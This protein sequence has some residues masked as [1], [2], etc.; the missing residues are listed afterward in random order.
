MQ[1]ENIRARIRGY[2]K[3]LTISD[4]DLIQQVNN[5]V[6][7]EDKRAR[8]LRSQ[9]RVKSAQVSQ[10]A[11]KKEKKCQDKFLETLEVLK[12]E[13]AEVKSQLKERNQDPEQT[14]PPHGM[15]ET[16][17]Q[18]KNVSKCSQC[19]VSGNARCFH[20]YI[21]GSDNHYTVG[22]QQN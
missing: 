9:N 6:S 3:D 22:C 16:G 11:G 18:R 15:Q 5:A 19:Q 10:V 13:V 2:L 8:K 1:D 21:C 7:T 17:N 20:C 4:K 12:T 14:N